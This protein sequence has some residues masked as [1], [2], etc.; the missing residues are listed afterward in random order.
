MGLF[1][2]TVGRP[3][4]Y[5][6]VLLASAAS[7]AG[8]VGTAA[9]AHAAAWATVGNTGGV[10]LTVRAAATPASA[11]LGLVPTGT[12]VS[13]S[14]QKYGAS[15]TNEA[16]FT[17][18]LWDYVPARG[19]YL[20]DAYMSTGYDF[21]IPGVPECSGGTTPPPAGSYVPIQ[22]N[23]GQ[24]T[25]WEDCGPTAVVTA[26]LRLGITPHEYGSGKRAAIERARAD[27]GLARG[28]LT[29][30]TNETQV[31]KAFRTY[32]LNTTTSWSFDASLAHVRSGRPAVMA[33]NTR[34]LPWDTNVRNPTVGVAHFLTVAGY[35]SA[36]GQY[37]VLDPIAVINSVKYTTRAVL[38]AYWD[39]NGGR[40]A[41]L[42]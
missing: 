36:T 5:A 17:S 13:I 6:A 22:Q 27:M 40:A 7:I 28:V 15:V 8:L 25:Q 21:R 18:T 26:L 37:L 16:G 4:R 11:A 19:G 20:A 30:G 3:R 2:R 1:S 24:V 38:L 29:G 31:N 10:G 33:G 14:C 35:D 9:P 41:V 42:A 34:A 32:G 12:G 39:N 23:Q